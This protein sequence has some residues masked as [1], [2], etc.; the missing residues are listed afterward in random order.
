MAGYAAVRSTSGCHDRAAP[1]LQAEPAPSG[2]M[3]DGHS[4]DHAGSGDH[5]HDDP[6]PAGHADQERLFDC[7]GWMCAA[8]ICQAAPDAL[9]QVPQSRVSLRRHGAPPPGWLALGPDRPPRSASRL[10]I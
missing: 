1:A 5:R 3:I 7:C 8:A 10:T 4:H 9:P 6:A 2:H